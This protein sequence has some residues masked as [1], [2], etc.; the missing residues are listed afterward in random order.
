M[1][2]RARGKGGIKPL[3]VENEMFSRFYIFK[4][5]HQK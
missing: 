4:K 1:E 2:W 3:F 5:W